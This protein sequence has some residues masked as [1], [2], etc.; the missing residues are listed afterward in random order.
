MITEFPAPLI[1]KYEDHAR[2]LL[3]GV[4]E[5]GKR[6]SFENVDSFASELLALRSL[7]YSFKNGPKEAKRYV[8]Y[9]RESIRFS[10]DT[11]LEDAVDGLIIG[12]LAPAHDAKLLGYAKS[13]D[14]QLR[15]EAVV[16]LMADEAKTL[17]ETYREWANGS[18]SE[19]SEYSALLLSMSS[20]FAEYDAEVA[21]FFRDAGADAKMGTVSDIGEIDGNPKSAVLH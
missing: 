18:E 3:T 20:L 1:E 2:S 7:A 12:L 4:S 19:K 21:G 17:A 6:E 15:A 16:D 13:G 8:T 5:S 9:L 11:A 10:D 14:D